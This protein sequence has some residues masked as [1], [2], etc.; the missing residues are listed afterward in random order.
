MVCLRTASEFMAEVVFELKA[1]SID[2]NLSQ[3]TTLSMEVSLK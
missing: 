3:L 2:L 1:I